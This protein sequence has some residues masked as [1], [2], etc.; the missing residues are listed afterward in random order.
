MYVYIMTEPGLFTVG[1]FDPDN[2]WCTDSDHAK[3]E[4]A[5]RRVAYLNG[6]TVPDDPKGDMNPVSH[7]AFCEHDPVV[8]SDGGKCQLR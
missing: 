3:R 5:A 4:S 7:C 2:R 1:F 8:C 6:S